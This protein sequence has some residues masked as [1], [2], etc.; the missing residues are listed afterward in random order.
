MFL[1]NG[2]GMTNM[3]YCKNCKS[4]TDGYD[5]E[6]H[7]TGDPLFLHHSLPYEGQ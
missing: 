2:T 7:V 3:L 1:L 5:S 6:E 4:Y